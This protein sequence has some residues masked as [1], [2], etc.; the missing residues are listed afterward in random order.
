MVV[1]RKLNLR[2][3]S[4]WFQIPRTDVERITQLSTGDPSVGLRDS[5][6]YWRDDVSRRH[7]CCH[8]GDRKKG[9]LSPV[10]QEGKENL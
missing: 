1:L 3:V 9:K 8:S 10:E 2:N 5:A 6:R 4:R 7:R